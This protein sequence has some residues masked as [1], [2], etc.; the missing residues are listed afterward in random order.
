MEKK[1]MYKK[2]NKSLWTGRVDIEDKELGKRWHEKI[3]FLDY[4]FKKKPGIAILGYA[5]DIGVKKNKGRVGAKEGC[6][7]LKNSMGNFAYHLKKIY[8][9]MQEKLKQQMI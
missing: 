6:D 1:L 4:P 9:M 5:C 8:Y 2:A 7:E 3:K